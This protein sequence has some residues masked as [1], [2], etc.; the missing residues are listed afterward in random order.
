MQVTLTFNLGDQSDALH[1]ANALQSMEMYRC[2]QIWDALIDEGLSLS[3]GARENEFY[4]KLGKQFDQLVEGLKI[5]LALD[6]PN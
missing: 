2:L 6:K 5:D 4:Q 3:N 1:H